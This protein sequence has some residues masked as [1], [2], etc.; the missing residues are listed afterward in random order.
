[1]ADRSNSPGPRELPHLVTFARAAE[2]GSFTDAAADLGV[3]QAA[4]SQ[5]IAVLEKE[6]RVSL[7]DRRAGRITLTEAGER[8]YELARK[9]LDLHEVAIA[10][11][12]GSPSSIA[13]VLPIAAS[14][15]P[16]ECYLP[17]LLSSFRDKYPKVHV[18]ASVS[19]SGS[20][21]NEIAKGIAALGLVGRKA[22][23]PSLESEPIGTDTLAL[24]LAPDHPLASRK[25]I[26]LAVLSRE[27]LILRE[28]GSGTR[29]ALKKGLERAGTSLDAMTVSLEVG[30]N[31]A[32]KDAV[33]RGLGASFMSL[34]IIGREL[35]AGELVSVRVRGLALTRDLYAVHHRRRPLSPAAAAFLHFLKANP[36]KP[37]RH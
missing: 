16:A 31:A 6:L 19:D 21:M 24:I 11:L 28:P 3:T 26:S 5:R 18:R 27:P 15:V 25:T 14:S 9:I 20:V 34:S 30:S 29:C 2:R 12:G 4:V 7:F 1:M 32:I 10:S 36:L 13:G 37:N 33:R 8:L 17:S 35:A 22:E 23:K